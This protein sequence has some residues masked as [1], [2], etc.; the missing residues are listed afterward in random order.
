M[1]FELTISASMQILPK[2]ITEINPEYSPAGSISM[3]IIHDLG[4]L[5]LVQIIKYLLS[6]YQFQTSFLLGKP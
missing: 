4:F 2:R 5:G 1:L 6:G 3:Q